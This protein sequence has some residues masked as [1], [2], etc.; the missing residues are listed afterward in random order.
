MTRQNAIAA[1]QLAELGITAESW[2]D[3]IASGVLLG[4]VAL[5]AGA[6]VG[7]CYGIRKTGEV[8]VLA[9]LPEYEG[10]GIGRELLARTVEDLTALGHQRLFLGCSADPDS[11]SYGFYRRL[12]WKSTGTLDANGDDVLELPVHPKRT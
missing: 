7:Y 2:D 8:A 5:T 3:D 12:G 9:L 10:R 1:A 4:H 6:I 11:R